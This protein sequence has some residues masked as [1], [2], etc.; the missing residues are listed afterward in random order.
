MVEA[1]AGAIPKGIAEFVKR[2]LPFGRFGTPEEV[3][4][5]DRV[6]RVAEGQLDQRHDRR[7]GRLSVADVLDVL[8]FS[9]TSC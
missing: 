1:P 2:E 8:T 5:V 9:V 4:D 6:S 7:R 3:G